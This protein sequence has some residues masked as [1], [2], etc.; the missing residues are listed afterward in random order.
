MTAQTDEAREWL[1]DD[2]IAAGDLLALTHVHRYAFASRLLSGRRVVDLCC[3]GGY[4]S[5]MLAAAGANVTAVDR[6]PDAVTEAGR[7]EGVTAVQADAL[8][9]VSRLTPDECDA[10]V[11][12]EG[13]EHVPDPEA[14]ARELGRLA[15]GGVALIV[16]IPNSAGFDEDNPFHVT[17]FGYESAMALFGLLG[18]HAVIG[19]YHAEGSLLL[20]PDDGEAVEGVRAPGE[21]HDLAWANHWIALV[22]VAPEAVTAARMRICAAPARNEYMR[23]LERA[24]L[25]LRRVNA[26]LARSHLGV[27]DAAAAAVIGRLERRTREAEQKA[28]ELQERLDV[29]IEVALQNDRHFQ[30]AR[31]ILESPRH[32]AVDRLHRA[33]LGLP[34]GGGLARIVGRILR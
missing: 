21:A 18:E 6:D 30:A 9:H 7:H 19:Q 24:N 4:G 3:G 29:E 32:R 26:K 23:A 17:T 5:A 11:C 22:G 10:V 27:H 25:E 13:I 12:F 20:D 8:E 33:V 15:A 2:E 31:A 1:A 14:V 28:R 16:S 34:G